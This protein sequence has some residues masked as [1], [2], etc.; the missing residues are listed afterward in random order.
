MSFETHLDD[1]DITRTADASTA[2]TEVIAA[3]H[4]EGLKK[5]PALGEFVDP[6]LADAYLD[7]ILDDDDLD[8]L[9]AQFASELDLGQHGV[10]DFIKNNIDT[11]ADERDDSTTAQF[12]R[13]PLDEWIQEHLISLVQERDKGS[14]GT[15]SHLWEFEAPEDYRETFTVNTGD[16]NHNNHSNFIDLIA[17]QSLDAGAQIAGMNY[18]ND[19]VWKEEFLRPFMSRNATVEH[20]VS[21]RR[22]A[23]EELWS[24]LSVRLEKGVDTDPEQAVQVSKVYEK[25]EDDAHLYVYT[26]LLKSVGDAH[27]VTYRAMQE[28]LKALSVIDGAASEHISVGEG[29]KRFWKLP[30]AFIEAA[31]FDDGVRAVGGD[32]E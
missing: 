9:V 6:V 23:V 18:K 10:E 28:E 31:T 32:P 19:G 2:A 17:N 13:L 7:G 14:S 3:V 20:Y 26:Q 11:R 4:E 25:P 5:Y 16:S 30:R 27:D 29:T 21:E 12:R 1:L 15:V 22:E 24:K 8:E